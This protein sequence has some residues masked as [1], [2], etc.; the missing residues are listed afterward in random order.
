M[1]HNTDQKTKQKS[2]KKQNGFFAWLQ[3]TATSSSSP[4]TFTCSETQCTLNPVQPT[5]T[6]T[7]PS[8][9][10]SYFSSQHE[11]PV[12]A[13]E[14]NYLSEIFPPD[15][16]EA[17][18]EAAKLGFLYSFISATPIHF[19]KDYFES[20]GLTQNQIQLANHAIRMITILSL[21]AYLGLLDMKSLC[22]AIGM[23]ISAI[24]LK[25]AG[26]NETISQLLPIAAVVSA[27]VLSDLSNAAKFLT[28]FII[29]AGSGWLGN[30]AAQ[31][32]FN[33]VS[34]FSSHQTKDTLDI[35]HRAEPA[36]IKKMM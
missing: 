3:N 16:Y 25:Y 21:S 5:A 26:T 30:R 29:A 13:E 35:S 4:P 12:A 24:A 15:Y 23:P 10:F 19:L 36:I 11:E 22:L 28:T 31:I 34:L 6:P 1:F 20:R 32:G 9:S 2:N 7:A 17:M 18:K 14:A 33:I 8:S 27:E